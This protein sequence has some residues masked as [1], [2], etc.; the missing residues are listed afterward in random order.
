MT[1]ISAADSPFESST[2]A[3][4]PALAV[5]G[6]IPL[7]AA[8]TSLGVWLWPI[9]AAPKLS[10]DSGTALSISMALARGDTEPLV[11]SLFPPLQTATYALLYSVGSAAMQASVPAV[12]SFLLALLLAAVA[13]HFT[14]SIAGATLAVLMLFFS[15]VFWEQ[16]GW[17]TFYP[18]FALLGYAGLYLGGRYAAE[19]SARLDLALLASLCLAGSLYAFTTALVFLPIPMMF[20]AFFWSR[21]RLCRTLNIYAL[22]VLFAAPWLVW[23]FLVG[24]THFY[25]HP[26]SWFTENHLQIVNA[27]FWQLPRESLADYMR[28]MLKAGFEAILPAPVWLLSVLGLWSLQRDKGPRAAAFVLACIGFFVITLAVIRPA[29]YP[30]YFYPIFPLVTLLAAFGAFTIWRT[31]TRLGP[32]HHVLGLGLACGIGASLYF[33]Y[34]TSTVSDYQTK[35]A[36]RLD[37]SPT[38]RDMRG[39]ARTIDDSRGVIGRDSSMQILLPDNLIH[40]VFLVS[41]PDY[42]SYLSWQDEES[43]VGVLLRY[44]IGWVLLYKDAERWEHGYNVWLERA[45]DLPPHHYVAIQDSDNFELAFDGGILQLYR[46]K[47]HKEATT[48]GV[49]TNGE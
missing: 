36:G 25:Y 33:G 28:T 5:L 41:E 16:A 46:L 23:H 19:K 35:Y 7:G 13:G 3:A 22:V 40:T 34:T 21:D 9:A 20:L 48:N 37:S 49:Q 14:R 32:A 38:Y 18:G 42:V 17:L 12:L 10:P 39:I 4:R 45:Y 6:W 29:P 47:K 44:D 1:A 43:V 30:R 15:N 8:F 31:L 26:L 24:G 11:D 2:P 27:E